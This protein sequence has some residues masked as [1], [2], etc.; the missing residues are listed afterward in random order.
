[1]ADTPIIVTNSH[2]LQGF[3]HAHIPF[4]S[5]QY[6]RLE[7]TFKQ[8]GREPVRRK[9]S[10]FNWAIVRGDTFTVLELDL[11]VLASRG[12]GDQPLAITLGQRQSRSAPRLSR[13]EENL[14][15]I[16]DVLASIGLEMPQGNRF[17]CEFRC[18]Y[19]TE[20]AE[21]MIRLPFDAPVAATS[22]L[23]SV[24][25]IRV[26]NPEGTEGVIIDLMP[27]LKTFVTAAHFRAELV[28]NEAMLQLTFEHGV[29]LVAEMLRSKGGER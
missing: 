14:K 27:D 24:R 16:K 12:S 21:P 1:M 23:T 4:G 3:V 17:I 28:V 7:D 10:R 18:A 22:K 5:A 2:L 26:T 29:S 6:E 9:V 19:S 11:S 15:D 20:E 13:R 8:L 25:G